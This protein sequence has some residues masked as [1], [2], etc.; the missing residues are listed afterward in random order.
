MNGEPV[1]PGP[2]ADVTV[3]PSFVIVLTLLLQGVRDVHG[4]VHLNLARSAGDAG[5]R[6]GQARP[7]DR[8][9]FP[10]LSVTS[11][12]PLSADMKLVLAGIGSVI[13]TPVASALPM[14]LS[15]SV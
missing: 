8:G 2:C 14:F 7:D 11:L 10:F 13:V 15:V 12:P 5:L 4:E 1:V 6:N 9:F 3:M